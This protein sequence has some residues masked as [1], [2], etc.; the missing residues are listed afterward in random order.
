LVQRLKDAA[1]GLT[2]RVGRLIENSS[3]GVVPFGSLI[4][5]RDFFGTLSTVTWNG[6]NK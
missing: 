4:A 6:P 2:S 1:L 5:F 3:H